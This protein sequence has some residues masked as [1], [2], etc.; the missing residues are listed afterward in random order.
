MSL[1]SLVKLGKLKI[2]FFGLGAPIQ[3]NLRLVKRASLVLYGSDVRS[4]AA[5]GPAAP[6][7]SYLALVRRDGVTLL[8]RE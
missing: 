6:L 1:E 8:H 7:P 3:A 4:I 5:L 2:S